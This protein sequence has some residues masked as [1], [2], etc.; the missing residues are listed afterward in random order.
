MITGLLARRDIRESGGVL[1][2][3]GMANA[4]LALGLLSIVVGA[5]VWILYA[6]GVANVRLEAG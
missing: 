5:M 1:P 3:Q 6:A 2:G 4:G